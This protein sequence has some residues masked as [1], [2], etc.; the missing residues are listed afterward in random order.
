M[1]SLQVIVHIEIETDSCCCVFLFVPFFGLVT[2]IV[3]DRVNCP[4]PY[5]CNEDIL[6]APN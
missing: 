4:L 6:R 5:T 3:L 1:A 2:S